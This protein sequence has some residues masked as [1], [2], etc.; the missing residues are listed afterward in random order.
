V[1]VTVAAPLDWLGQDGVFAVIVALIF[2]S[3]DTNAATSGM[4]N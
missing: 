1:A 3:P 2:C 4:F